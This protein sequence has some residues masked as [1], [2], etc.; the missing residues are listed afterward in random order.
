M[1]GR[2]TSEASYTGHVTRLAAP[3]RLAAEPLVVAAADVAASV[4]AP[5]AARVDRTEVP[6]S[7]VRALGAAGLLAPAAPAD[8]GGG[9][10]PAA[11]A[12]TI[13]GL[14]AGA[15]G[16]TWFVAAQH[17]TPVRMLLATDN[18]E[19]RNRWLRPFASGTTLSG[20]ALAQLRRPGPPAVSGQ[21]VDGGWAVSGDVPWLSS[22]GLA[23][24]VLLGFREGAS[25]VFA[26]VPA[27]AQPG[28]EPGPQLALAAMS[29]ARTVTVR[30]S[31]YFVA[32]ADV[33]A[34]LPFADWAE[35]DAAYTA[36][37]N[38]AVF[39]L[40]TS[41]LR[42]MY[43]EGE[44]RSEVATMQLADRLAG[45]AVDLRSAAYKLVDEVPVGE[46]VPE[47]LAVRG[48]ALELLAVSSAALVAAGAGASM[49]LDHPAQRWAREALFHLIQA[50]TPTVRGAT[51]TAI[52]DHR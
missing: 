33:V 49:S 13:T 31:S 42:R 8:V 11:A 40:L 43:D 52:S 45:E 4:L 48:A 32:E 22:W 30:L 15:C 6:L 47:R 19:L 50:Q 26:L 16:A 21:V 24:R 37:V 34:R 44:R 23:E 12:R 14:L 46:R 51:M 1:V 41:V 9:G 17:G 18:A 3:S 7:H 2:V 39:G 27:A 25:V 35:T 38:P 5:A 10:A 29:A 28:F 36:N 20:I